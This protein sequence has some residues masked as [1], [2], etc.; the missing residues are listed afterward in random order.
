VP[1]QLGSRPEVIKDG[2]LVIYRKHLGWCVVVDGR[3]VLLCAFMRGELRKP[4]L[5]IQEILIL[6]RHSLLNNNSTK[7]DII[8]LLSKE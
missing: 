1:C 8:S 2:D 6:H 3:I 7:S 4:S 5:E